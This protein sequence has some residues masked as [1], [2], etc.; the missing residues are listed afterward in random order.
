[1]ITGPLSARAQEL[2]AQGAAFV[3]A[4]VVRV[5]H[6]T[7][8]KPGNVAL[9]HEDGSM[10]GFV[11]G[12]CAQNSVRLYS[13][14]A[15]ERGEPLLLRILPDGPGLASVK[16]GANANS[17]AEDPESHPPTPTTLEVAHDEGSVTVQNPCL[18]GGA[19]EV[20]LE[21]YLP[22][23]RVIVA[24]DTPIAA[25]L[26]RLGPDLGLDAVDSRGG[27]SG[28]VVPS[29]DDLALVVAA[30]G[31]DEL[32]I[33]RAALEA[34]VQYV[35]LVASRKRGAG[36][37]DQLR[38][39]GLP[40]ELLARIDT[41][42]GLDIGAR[43]PAR[44][45]ALDPGLDHP[46]APPGEHGPALVGGRSA[47]RGRS[48]LR[49]DRGRERR[50]AVGAVRGRHALLL[51][52]GLSPRLR[53]PARVGMTPPRV[54][55]EAADEVRQLAPDVETLAVRLGAIDYLVDE[56]LATSMFLSL[57]LPQPLLLEG[58]AGVGKTEAGK[59]L[60]AVLDTPLVRLQ[61]YDGID[62][63]EALYEW[64]YPRQLLS[65]RLAEAQGAALSEQDLFGRE[66]LI[67]RPL[68]RALEHPGPRPA[69]LLIDEI[70]RADDDFEA[71]LLELL[72]EAA[73][74]IP[75]LGT[76]RA[77]HPP[78][79]VLTSN[80]T[81]DLHD[82]VKRRCLYQ[83]IDYPSAEREVEIVRRRV[84]GSSQSLAV[85]VADAVSRM[86]DSDIQKPPGV[87]EAIDWVAALTVL[88]CLRVGRRRDRPDAR[89]GAEVRRGP[90]GHPRCRAR[91]AGG[92][93]MTEPFRVR[94]L[95][96]DLPAVA[97]TFGRRLH[98]AGVPVTAERAAW[99]ARA[100]AA[101][102]PVS[103]RRLYWTARGVFVT[104]S[105]QARAFDAVFAS[106]F[107]SPSPREDATPA[108]E[109]ASTEATGPDERPSRGE[110]NTAE[111]SPAGA[112]TIQP[113]VVRGAGR[114]RTGPDAGQR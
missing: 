6:P 18:S 9:V 57:R 80:R 38:G 106:V 58:E 16:N 3:T 81:R 74:T 35:G 29:A 83:W 61:C 73:V 99:F 44:G 21:P 45:R 110:A 24:G 12:V 54:T 5:E 108:P 84:P 63:A 41:P 2:T 92:P 89:V 27:D 42:A 102:E 40:E 4:T 90:G 114:R 32:A 69:V 8:A 72:A 37:L 82:A 51:R 87:A 7:S 53:A 19:I 47:D 91:A 95:G 109:D 103:R 86:R 104:D 1:M 112:A 71:F 107:G 23:P 13:L 85:Q 28:T 68:L 101:V 60:A 76:I 96:L 46:G 62:A 10:E 65:I 43:T 55:G 79:I 20:F 25:A 93:A 22:P 11:G 88:R 30:H 49:H 111:S 97:A 78:I 17:R 52:R 105:T 66:Y 56:A 64:N 15:I 39:E 100:L 75:E 33:L 94:T 67:R 98:D 14:K 113:A 50:R 36:V 34:E 77:T 59:A 26:L 31:R 70:D 48:D